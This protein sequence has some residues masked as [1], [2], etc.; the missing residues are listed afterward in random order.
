MSSALRRG[1]SAR[2]SATHVC[3]SSVDIAR[4]RSRAMPPSGGRGLLHHS[5]R[6]VQGRGATTS[7]I[8]RDHVHGTNPFFPG[9][10]RRGPSGPLFGEDGV[11]SRGSGKPEPLRRGQARR[12]PFAGIG[13]GGALS[14]GAGR[15][16]RVGPSRIV[17]PHPEPNYPV[18]PPRL[19][20]RRLS[21]VMGSVRG[22]RYPYPYPYRLSSSRSVRYQ[23]PSY[24]LYPGSQIV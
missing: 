8:P 3:R 9:S 4:R 23:T 12:S 21:T 22:T 6:S 18:P 11:P 24:G 19:S 16:L 7:L 2:P 13:H 17:G 1:G 14:R 10:C 5:L 15:F 20:P